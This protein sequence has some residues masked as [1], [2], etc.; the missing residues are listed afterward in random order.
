[1]ARRLKARE[2]LEDFLGK[3]AK[4]MS[5][6]T[7]ADKGADS[8]EAKWSEDDWKNSIYDVLKEHG[9]E[10]DKDDWA[11]AF[12]D[13]ENTYPKVTGVPGYEGT[14]ID[15]GVLAGMLTD[16]P[17]IAKAAKKWISENREALQPLLDSKDFVDMYGG[18]YDDA[19]DTSTDS[20]AI[21]V[22][23]DTTNTSNDDTS[24]S[25]GYD[26]DKYNVYI[27]GS[28]DDES[29]DEPVSDGSE[30]DELIEYSTDKSDTEDDESDDST[31]RN[32]ADTLANLRL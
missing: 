26:I 1:M 23:D 11:E 16:E 5:E 12:E 28:E 7:I 2:A 6:R 3:Q 4:G 10:F 13:Y 30:D 22:V 31:Q 17:E 29:E 21:E 8:E 18:S 24:D 32:I 27:E 25:K 15:E 14:E 9:T 20:T 19:D